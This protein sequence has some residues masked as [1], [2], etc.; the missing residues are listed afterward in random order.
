MESPSAYDPLAASIRVADLRGY[1][2][3]KGWEIKPFKRPQVVR[4][5]GPPDDDGH[6]IVLLMPASEQ[7]SDYSR[8]VQEL[9]ASLA[10]IEQRPSAEIVRNIITP[11]CDILHFRLAGAATVTGTLEFSFVGQFFASLRNLLV[12]AACGEFRPQPFF[13]RALKQAVHFAEK[14]RLRPA[15][16]GS[17]R[18]DVETPIVPPANAAQV[19]LKAYPIERLIMVSL[20]EGLGQLQHSVG[21]GKT[22]SV[23]QHK[24]LNAN[25]CEA[26]LGMRPEVKDAK[27]EVGVSWSPTWPID[28]QILPSDV[29]FEGR[30]F[31]QIDAIGRALRAGDE[32]QRRQLQGRVI[33]LAADDPVR[34]GAGPLLA[35]LDVETANA[36]AHVEIALTPEQYRQAAQAHLEGLKIIVRGILERSGRKWQLFDIADFQVAK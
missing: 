12:F 30:D 21:S 19:Q 4:F 5:E 8:R 28:V 2:V 26:L 15:P 20:M 10:V 13:P 7:L 17:F 14:C 25:I 34:G 9:V 32:P 31:E 3:A 22:D 11:T 33:R 23:F 1:L 6:P 35:V 18:V 27:L 29:A 36:P 16:A 24:R